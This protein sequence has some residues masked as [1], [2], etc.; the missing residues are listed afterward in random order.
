MSLMIAVSF[1][2]FRCS[3]KVVAAAALSRCS[4]TSRD[5][6]KEIAKLVKDKEYKDLKNLVTEG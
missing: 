5:A 3:A 4:V 2:H 6:L 1:P